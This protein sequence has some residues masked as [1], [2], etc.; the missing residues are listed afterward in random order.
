MIAAPA[1]GGGKTT[2][3]TGILR[4]LVERGLKAAA[5]KCGPDYI[6]PMFH[7]EVLGVPS[8]NL[9]LFLV[10]PDIVGG[11]FR[12]AAADADI[13]VVEGVMGY[14]DGVGSTARA[15]SWH[16]SSET[17]TPAVLVVQP[18]GA[19]LSLAAMV[20]GF[21]G[22][23]ENSMIRGIILNRCGETYYE[24][25]KP[26]LERETG[27]R[28]FGHIPDMPEASLESRHLGLATPDSIAGLREKIRLL[29]DRMRESLDLPGLLALADDAP[30]LAGSLPEI[31]PLPGAPVRVAVA[32]DKAFCFYYEDN[33]DLLRSLGA[34]LVFFSP[35]EDER[36][37]AGIGGLYIGGGYPE[38]YAGELAANAPMRRAVREAVL[39]GMPTLAEC[40]GFLYLQTRLAG[41]DGREH[42]MAGALEGSAGN[43]GGLRRFGYV[44]LRARRDNVLC[45]AGR[46]IPAHEFHHWDSDK[47]GDAFVATKAASGDSWDC[48]AAGESLYAGFPHIHFWSDPGMA[49]RFVRAAIRRGA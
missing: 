32:R 24:R 29:A 43:G 4:L 3:A 18:K 19:F 23:Q 30:E 26:M 31:A 10:R 48:V 46:E 44:A 15:S 45:E 21:L 1:S 36:L 7:R 49:A 39:A 27:L 8:R 42:A 33:L 22:F 35:L 6:D 2:A 20:K 34:E 41:P 11:L 12:R 16:L 25:L 37:P 28:V 40:G 17:G 38:L 47:P 14:Y 5:F 13:S 9:D